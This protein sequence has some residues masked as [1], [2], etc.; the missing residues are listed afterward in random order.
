[1]SL[2]TPAYPFSRTPSQARL[3]LVPLQ[4]LPNSNITSPGNHSLTCPKTA[5]STAL[6]IRDPKC[7]LTCVSQ[8][9]RTQRV[10]T[11]AQLQMFD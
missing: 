11:E 8:A 10:W 4:D 5:L 7:T 6:F 9:L 2:S 1:M 3:V